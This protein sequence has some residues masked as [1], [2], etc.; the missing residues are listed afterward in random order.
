MKTFI[1][2]LGAILVLCGVL[3]LAYYYFFTQTNGL[4]VAS[5]VLELVGLVTF[6]LTNKYI[7]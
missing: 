6:I 3:C 1:K 4:L 5:L 7:D 2:Y